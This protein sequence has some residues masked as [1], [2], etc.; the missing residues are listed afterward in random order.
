M[1]ADPM[2]ALRCFDMT[3][4]VA[5]AMAKVPRNE[6]PDMPDRMIASTAVAH[7]TRLVSSDRK[8]RNSTSLK[9]LIPV[10]W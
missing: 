1:V 4:D 6:V 8:I 7:G 10:I 5:R 2:I 3:M 9:Q